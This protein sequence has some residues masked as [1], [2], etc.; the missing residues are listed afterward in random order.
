MIGLLSGVEG[1]WAGEPHS[2]GY[3][4]C[5]NGTPVARGR[6][7]KN[8]V[9]MRAKEKAAEWGDG[10]LARRPPDSDGRYFFGNANTSSSSQ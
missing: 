10:P 5:E 2:P 1:G 6:G 3:L 4:Q 9:C 8:D 7:K